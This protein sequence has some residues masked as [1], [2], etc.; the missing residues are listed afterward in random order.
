MGTMRAIV[1]SGQRTGYNA[2]EDNE[3]DTG[4]KLSRKGNGS[5]RVG[6]KQ[7]VHDMDLDQRPYRLI[8]YYF[9]RS[10][11]KARAQS[12]GQHHCS[13]ICDM[14]AS[15]Y[16]KEWSLTDREMVSWWHRGWRKSAREWYAM[17][18]WWKH[19]LNIFWAWIMIPEHSVL[20]FFET[21]LVHWASTAHKF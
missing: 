18:M 9:L 4:S 13:V 16:S 8:T 17:S 1:L 19:S 12:T 20:V 6:A 14:V 11:C 2:T 3:D 5:A 10:F 21:E 15:M 7:A